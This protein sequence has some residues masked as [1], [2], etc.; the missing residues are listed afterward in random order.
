MR[1]L[2]GH[3]HATASLAYFGE[4]EAMRVSAAFDACRLETS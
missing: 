3:S 4:V 1:V 2:N